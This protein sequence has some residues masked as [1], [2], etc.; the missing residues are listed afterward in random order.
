MQILILFS[1]FLPRPARH[2]PLLALP[3]RRRSHSARRRRLLLPLMLDAR[4]IYANGPLAGAK[5]DAAT[6]AMK[7]YV[8]TVILF[9]ILGSSRLSSPLS[10]RF[11]VTSAHSLLFQQGRRA[12]SPGDIF[13]P[14]PARLYARAMPPYFISAAPRYGW[15]SPGDDAIYR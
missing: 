15:R 5:Y 13:R 6:S 12:M 3:G 9:I 14:A 4:L 8:A 11:P 10:T 1:Q 2:S 7:P